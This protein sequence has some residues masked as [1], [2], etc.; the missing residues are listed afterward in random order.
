VVTV[1]PL[2]LDVAQRLVLVRG[3]E[4][5]LTPTEYDLLKVLITYRDK[6]LTG[7]LL[8]S[9][10]WVLTPMVY[11]LILVCGEPVTEVEEIQC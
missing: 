7:T 8:L 3:Q 2:T 9:Q 11:W 10:V 5:K 1:G 4:V 6:V